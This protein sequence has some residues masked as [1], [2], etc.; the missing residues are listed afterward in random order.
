MPG[1]NPSRLPGKTLAGKENSWQ[2]KCCRVP[3]SK[4]AQILAEKQKSWQPKSWRDPAMNLAKKQIHRGQNLGALLLG[5]S[6]LN[7][8]SCRKHNSRQDSARFTVGISAKFWTC[9]NK[10]FLFEP[11]SFK[12]RLEQLYSITCQRVVKICTV[13]SIL[14]NY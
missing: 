13:K 1:R 10:Y 9:C 12:L 2:P 7:K 11:L 4:L 5:I 3:V 8:I 6:A 14:I